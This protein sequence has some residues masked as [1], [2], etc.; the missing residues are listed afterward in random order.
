MTNIGCQAYLQ[1]GDADSSS[2]STSASTSNPPNAC[3]KRGRKP[4]G[5]KII[6]TTNTSVSDDTHPL[7]TVFSTSDARRGT[8][9]G[10]FPRVE[11][12]PMT[13]YVSASAVA[14]TNCRSESGSPI[15]TRR[16]MTP[17]ARQRRAWR[18]TLIRTTRSCTYLFGRCNAVRLPTKVRVPPSQG[19][20]PC[21]R[22]R[23]NP[24]KA[25]SIS[26]S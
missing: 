23:P 14:I 2:T 16:P 18:N 6:P 5:G 26:P 4:K 11:P 10:H 12:T 19:R 17:R 8:L 1:C 25:L 21:R 20:H 13:A 24:P 22:R 9:P 7:E 3:K 15:E